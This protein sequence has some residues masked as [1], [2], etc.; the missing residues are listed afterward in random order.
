MDDVPIS[1]GINMCGQILDVDPR[2]GRTIVNHAKP[3][4]KG[5][6]NEIA[7]PH[8]VTVTHA[9]GSVS[10]ATIVGATHSEL[11][12]PDFVYA[13]ATGRDIKHGLSDAQWHACVMRLAAQHP[14]KVGRQDGFLRVSPRPN[15][16]YRV[17]VAA[18]ARQSP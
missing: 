1:R 18:R 11:R 3:Y 7:K 6:W 5:A 13:V 4:S 10:V 12:D 16:G 14:D 15:A 2:T 17:V 9:D 8:T